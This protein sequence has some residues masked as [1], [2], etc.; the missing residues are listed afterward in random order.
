M[1][2]PKPIAKPKTLAQADWTDAE[3]KEMAFSQALR[4]VEEDDVTYS[5]ADL[6][7]RPS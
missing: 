4:G 5:T 3:F 6:Q 2:P 7:E 1:S